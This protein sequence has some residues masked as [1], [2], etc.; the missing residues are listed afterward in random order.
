M[1]D[2]QRTEQNDE[3]CEGHPMDNSN[4]APW[5]LQVAL[6]HPSRGLWI[7]QIHI[8]FSFY[9]VMPGGQVNTPQHINE[10]RYWQWVSHGLLCQHLGWP[11]SWLVFCFPP[12][13]QLF[14]VLFLWTKEKQSRKL[15]PCLQFLSSCFLPGLCTKEFWFLSD[16]CFYLL[17][18][19]GDTSTSTVVLVCTLKYRFVFSSL[20]PMIAL[21]FLLQFLLWLGFICYLL[22]FQCKSLEA[23]WRARCVEGYVSQPL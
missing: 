16:F 3:A 6:F 18:L 12:L 2:G 5:S 9:T 4:I 15:L 22:S 8:H 1:Q 7:T 11:F 17:S 14:K 23:F 10:S 21:N 13:P 20:K 19:P